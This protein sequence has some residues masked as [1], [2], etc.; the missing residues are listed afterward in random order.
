MSPTPDH[1]IL[2]GQWRPL[3]HYRCPG[4]PQL[5]VYTPLLVPGVCVQ[6]EHAVAQASAAS[7]SA[8]RC[9]A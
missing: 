6:P 1:Q 5:T 8:A 3:G 7:T 2:G 4:L 9:G